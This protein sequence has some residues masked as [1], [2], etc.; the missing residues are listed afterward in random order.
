MR[1]LLAPARPHLAPGGPGPA[2]RRPSA[3]TP[4]DRRHRTT[5]E[6]S[7]RR[8]PGRGRR[9]VLTLSVSLPGLGVGLSACGTTFPGTTLAQQVTAWAASTGFAAS[10][11]T[12]RGDVSRVTALRADPPPGV[13]K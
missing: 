1:P 5:A 8:C 4:G 3:V 2:A 10:V 9:A 6:A 12:V 13:L 11:T 7:G